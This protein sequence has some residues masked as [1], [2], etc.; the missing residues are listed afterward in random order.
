[1]PKLTKSFLHKLILEEINNLNEPS[2]LSSKVSSSDSLKASGD[3]L[4]QLGMLTK[5]VETFKEKV[6]RGE[7]T[8]AI[9]GTKLPTLLQELHDEIQAISKEPEKYIGS[10]R[11]PASSKPVKAS[12]VKP[13]TKVV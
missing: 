8:S 3:L 13:T 6:L 5:A 7:M 12:I 2:E 9:A 10:P 1:M 4:S 11:R